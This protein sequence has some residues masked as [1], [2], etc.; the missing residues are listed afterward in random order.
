MKSWLSAPWAANWRS[1]HYFNAYRLV[2][3]AMFLLAVLFPHDW[4]NRLNFSA[5]PTMIGLSVGYLGLTA[6]GLLLSIYWPHRFNLQLS[7]QVLLDIFL[8]SFLMLL[9]GGVASGLSGILMVTLAAA[10]LVGR[11]R[12]V[13]FYAAVATLAVL[14]SQIYGTIAYDFDVSGILQAGV[15]SSAFFATAI[16]ARLLGQRVMLNEALA[17]ERGVALDNWLRISQ[18]IV[19]RMPGG[20]LILDQAGCVTQS[21][22]VARHML[23]LADGAGENLAFI[24]P[25]LS[26]AVHEWQ[27]GQGLDAVLLDGFNGFE[28]SARFESTTSSAGETLVF[29]EDLGRIKDQAQQLKLASLGRLTASIAHEI[30]NPLAAISHAGEL[31]REEAQGEI[32][33]R[34]LRIVS[35]NVGRLDRIVRE[36]LE[37]GRQDRVRPESLALWDLCQAFVENFAATEGLADGVIVLEGERDV[38]LGFDRAHWYQVMA[39]LVGNAARYAS[40]Q[41]GAIRLHLSKGHDGRIELHVS[42]DGPGITDKVR[43]QIFEP[44]FTTAHSGTGLGLYIARELCS[45]NG[46]TLE[47]AAAGAGGAHFIISGRS[48]CQQAEMNAAYMGN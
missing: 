40:R 13:L 23:G 43:D 15:I 44:F 17:K 18:R 20:V 9:G 10:S 25:D 32:R 48:D 31:L 37:L 42:D 47:L 24:A 34:L 35:D 36:V 19:E 6:A 1:F 33:D 11:G 12:M 14:L 27:L 21:N 28:L 45:A 38:R 26:A 7:S 16:L 8:V 2:V 3:A 41:P 4:N 46:A 5:T 22:P 29:L 30:R 39:N